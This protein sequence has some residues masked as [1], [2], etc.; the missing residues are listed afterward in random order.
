MKI[1]IRLA[2]LLTAAIATVSTTAAQTPQDARITISH[3]GFGSLKADLKALIDLTLPAEKA[4][5]E[6]IEGYIDTFAIGVDDARPIFVSAMTGI[7][8]NASL[9]WVPL[10][11]GQQ[12][13]KEF[14]ENL[15]SLGY[16]IS[17][18]AKET[19]LFQISQDPEYG[20]L[21]VHSDIRYAVFVLT[22]DKAALPALKALI[23][24]VKIPDGKPE[25]SMSAEI[26][27]SDV[28]PAAQKHRRES[29]GE[30]RGFSMDAIKKRP[31][32]SAT[33]FALRTLAMKQQMDEGERLLAEAGRIGAILMLNKALPEAPTST[34][35][36]SAN[37]IPGSTLAAAIADIGTQ[38]DAFA[39]IARFKG[40]ALSFRLNHPVDPMRQANFT[41]FLALTEKDMAERLKASKERSDSE[42]AVSNKVTTGVLDVIRA[43]INAG[44]IN[45]FVE[46]V[47]DGKGEF[48][49][50]ASFSSPA[51]A[52]LSVV[53]PDLAQAGKG[54]V[55]EMNVD[56]QGDVAIH[57]VQLAE[58]YVD[59]VDKMFG[60]KKDLFVGVGPAHVWLASGVGGKEELKQTIKDLGEPQSSTTPLHVE[61]KV[62]PWVQRMEE[63]AKKDPPGKTPEELE[64]QR[65]W[66]RRRARAIAS[67]QNGNDVIVL[68]FKVVDGEV[69]G[70]LTM[71][72]G[73]LRFAGKLMSAFSKANF[74]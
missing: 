16:E 31:E 17:R 48:T 18:D 74:E 27:N 20:W 69:S 59:L 70:E 68:D 45:G 46:S 30:V 38:P 29:F 56:Q 58:G 19:S 24:K 7:K 9:I 36:V 49:T 57:R 62:L 3:P 42:K 10:S 1:A 50:V 66:A 35:K 6:N 23:L 73:L 47:P 8:P 22:N 51:A 43:S 52:K 26:L 39:G 34:L 11:N 41:E 13:F 5:W 2:I 72:T 12:L 28:S 60:V 55:V 65:E 21:R 33:E 53:L 40:S 4:Q 32:E 67:C 63:I 44:W 71:E 54:N 37:G 64:L 15:E 14:R 61:I 25:E